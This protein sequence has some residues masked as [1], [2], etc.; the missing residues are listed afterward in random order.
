MHRRI[1][2]KCDVSKT[3]N[4]FRAGSIYCWD[5]EVDDHNRVREKIGE[6]RDVLAELLINDT[7]TPY[8][9]NKIRKLI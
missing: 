5:C 2:H 7:L 3:L 9:E 8:Y 4:A 6:M 1:C